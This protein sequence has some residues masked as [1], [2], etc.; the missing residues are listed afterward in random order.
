VRDCRIVGHTHMLGLGLRSAR[1]LEMGN[2]VRRS[3]NGC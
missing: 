3:G 2:E 1:L